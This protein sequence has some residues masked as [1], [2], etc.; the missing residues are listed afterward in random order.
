M[1]EWRPLLKY[2][3]NDLNLANILVDMRGKAWLIDFAKCAALCTVLL[4]RCAAVYSSYR[5]AV[6]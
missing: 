5:N 2:E 6:L 1:A 3:H 4:A